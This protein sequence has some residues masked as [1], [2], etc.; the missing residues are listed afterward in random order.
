[1]EI[2]EVGPDIQRIKLDNRLI[3]IIGTA[4]ISPNSV[5]KVR[6]TLN[7]GNPDTVCV[8]LC[9]SR[10]ENLDNPDKWKQT[11]LFQIIRRNQGYLLMVQLI[12]SAFQR[13]LGKQMGVKPGDEMRAAV[14]LAREKSLPL[15]PIDRDIKITMKRAWAGSGFFSLLKIVAALGGSLFTREKISEEQ[16]EELKSR[17]V[18]TAA[19]SELSAILPGVKRSL[20]DERDRYM[21]A[22]ILC[23][24]GNDILAVV[25]AGHVP[26]IIRHLAAGQLDVSDIDRVDSHSRYLGKVFNYF[27]LLLGISVIAGLIYFIGVKNTFIAFG[28]W[29]VVNGLFAAGAAAL[30]MAH[31]FTIIITFFA[32]P[33]AAIHPGFAVGWVSALVEAYLRNPRVQDFEEL[34]ESEKFRWRLLN[35]RVARILLLLILP[36]LGSILGTAVAIYVLSSAAPS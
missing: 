21:A 20:I 34:I 28:T 14:E 16:L 4:H 5:E 15:S 33:V 6:Q 26:G 22:K 23:A 18:L 8:E 12:I 30:C 10:L 7:S 35:N 11:D 17:D 31:P 1:M 13:R 32:S 27:L 36:N 29:T 25:G 9:A 19:L 3:T 2:T 24:P